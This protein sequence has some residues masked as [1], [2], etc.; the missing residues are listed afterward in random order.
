MEEECPGAAIQIFLIQTAYCYVLSRRRTARAGPA[1]L[2]AVMLEVPRVR[3]AGQMVAER[4]VCVDWS[5]REHGN[6]LA[7]TVTAAHQLRGS[8]GNRLIDSLPVLRIGWHPEP[9]R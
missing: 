5:D 4:Q 8:R 6:L 7:E 3:P 9:E 2:I 1:T